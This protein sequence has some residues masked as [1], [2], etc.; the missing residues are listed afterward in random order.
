LRF[1]DSEQFPALAEQFETENDVL[2]E[3]S[4]DEGDIVVEILAGKSED[5]TGFLAERGIMV[6]D[7]LAVDDEKISETV[8]D[9]ITID[10]AKNTENVGDKDEA[11]SS[12]ESSEE[13]DEPKS[14]VD[15]II[16]EVQNKRSKRAVGRDKSRTAKRVGKKENTGELIAWMKSPGKSDMSGV[17]TIAD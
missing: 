1:E 8:E 15:E 17:D 14:E 16:N 2:L 10:D 4:N 5:F 3:I 11:E 7:E 6:K 9:A 12:I 13:P